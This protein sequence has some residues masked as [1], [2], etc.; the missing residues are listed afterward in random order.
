MLGRNPLRS[1]IIHNNEENMGSIQKTKNENIVK[2]NK[3]KMFIK[4]LNIRDWTFP[5][6]KKWLA[7]ALG[8]FIAFTPAPSAK[9][10]QDTHISIQ[11]ILKKYTSLNYEMLADSFLNSEYVLG[12]KMYIYNPVDETVKINQSLNRIYNYPD[13]SKVEIDDNDYV[14][15]TDKYGKKTNY[16][17]G[18]YVSLYTNDDGLI[19]WQS[20]IKVSTATGGVFRVIL[21][22]GN[23]IE[24]EFLKKED[25]VYY[26]IK[27]S[28][29]HEVFF[30]GPTIVGFYDFKNDG[31]TNRI[32]YD[33]LDKDKNKI[34]TIEYVCDESIG[35]YGPHFGTELGVN[36]YDNSGKLIKTLDMG[37]NVHNRYMGD[38]IYPEKNI[39][40]CIWNDGT[41]TLY[42]TEDDIIQ[43]S[44]YPNGKIVNV[45]DET[46]TIEQEDGSHILIGLYQPAE[47]IQGNNF[48][49]Y[50]GDTAY[51]IRDGVIEMKKINTDELIIH[52]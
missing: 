35:T 34:G 48:T 32:K 12:N 7:F 1:E 28:Y 17:K 10:P 29:G 46:V 40:K 5:I 39:A 9:A 8:Y 22:D 42:E 23:I 25:R 13:G 47:S 27:S 30:Q 3:I 37:T 14:I 36:W 43:S 6:S 4:N 11:D 31:Y 15:R 19:V 52:K 2:E 45:T 26:K 41:E 18:K 20:D 16:P 21:P 50:S 38:I 51:M 49:F 44:K 24:K 33:W